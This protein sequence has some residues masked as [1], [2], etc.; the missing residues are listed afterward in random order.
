MNF[1]V[2]A[3]LLVIPIV[4]APRTEPAAD[5]VRS[6][7]AL[8]GFSY[9]AALAGIDHARDQAYEWGQGDLGRQDADRST[10]P[11][12]QPAILWRAP[13]GIGMEN[14][15]CG[16]AGCDHA[17]APPFHFEKE[18][19][20]GTFP[21]LTVTDAKGRTWSVKFGVKV[22]PESFSS[23]FV[24][25][26]GYVVEPSYYVA[27]G[28]LDDASK[29]SRARGYVKSDG[30]F[31]RAR[32]QLRD[33]NTLE[34]LPKHAWSLTDNP[35][36]GTHELAGLRVLLMMLSN[37]DVKDFRS[38]EESSNTAVFRGPGGELLY[39]FFDWGSTLGRWG[40]ITR[41]TRS[42]CTGFSADTPRLITGVRD[43]VVVWGYSGKHEEIVRNG[44]TVDDLRW[45]D[46]YLSAITDEQI[47][48]GL[49]AS[50]ANDRENATC[51]EA[52]ESRIHQVQTVA[53]TGQY[54][55]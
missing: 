5:Y 43:N 34:F 29:L 13:S 8:N 42:D 6:L 7:T 25:A 50:G 3:I 14:W 10:I 4:R 36:V 16:S 49:K 53:R 41:R 48:A 24:A 46:P 52:L 45:L 30:T 22:M 27:S 9:A 44:I 51:T 54:T 32:F 37:W 55:R 12:T 28:K 11:A 39:S 31:V 33:K 38:G 2:T 18:D 15:T 17:P 1:R 23:R 19:M 47:R 35:F 21:K 20:E 26:L 40:N